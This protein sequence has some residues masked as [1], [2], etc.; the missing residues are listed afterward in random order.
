[1]PMEKKTIWK[2]IL[3]NVSEKCENIEVTD[4]Y[5][6]D[7]ITP[8]QTLID[9][10]EA[11]TLTPMVKALRVIADTVEEYIKENGDDFYGDLQINFMHLPGEEYYGIQ[12]GDGR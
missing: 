8:S 3:D 6:C 7:L 5:P 11:D 10:E 4:G 2:T 1:M 12:I 9:D